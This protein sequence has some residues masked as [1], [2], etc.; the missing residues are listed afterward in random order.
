MFAQMRTALG[1]TKG[2]DILDHVHSLPDGDQEAAHEKIKAIEREAMAD[3]K[4]QEGLVELME[5]LKSKGIR[6]GI[7]TRNFE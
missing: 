5:Y 3:Q 7:C 4:P 2:T 1:I 6:K